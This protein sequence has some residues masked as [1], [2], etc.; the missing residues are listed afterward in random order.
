MGVYKFVAKSY[1]P[2]A[3]VLFAL[4]SLYIAA[5]VRSFH[6]IVDFIIPLA[7]F[8]TLIT[9]LHF[10]WRNETSSRLQHLRPRHDAEVV[11]VD[12]FASGKTPGGDRLFGGV[13]NSLDVQ[14]ADNRIYVRGNLFTAGAG[15]LFGL[16]YRIPFAELT[17][18]ERKG[19]RIRLRF[20]GKEIELTVHDPDRFMRAIGQQ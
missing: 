14:V 11:Y 6:A 13:M 12:H 4:T 19:D 10:M 9:P 17:A 15:D 16:N 18:C 8:A 5:N 20:D 7:V 1:W 2:I 3:I